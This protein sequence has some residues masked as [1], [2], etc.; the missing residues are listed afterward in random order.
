MPCNVVFQHLL[1]VA[2]LVGARIEMDAALIYG[3][4][5]DDVAPLVGARIEIDTVTK[6]FNTD[7]R[8]SPR[9]SED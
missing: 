6:D 9:G 1:K 5:Y 7:H 3:T 8:R 4:D 2:P